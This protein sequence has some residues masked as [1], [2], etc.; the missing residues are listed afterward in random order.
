MKRA[1]SRSTSPSTGGPPHTSR[2]LEDLADTVT[3]AE[4]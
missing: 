4:A 1:Q 2:W 3:P